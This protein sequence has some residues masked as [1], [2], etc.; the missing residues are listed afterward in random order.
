MKAS[1][2][3]CGHCGDYI[4]VGQVPHQQHTAACGKAPQLDLDAILRRNQA[5]GAYLGDWSPNLDQ[6][7]VDH[8]GEVKRLVEAARRLE[9]ANAKLAAA[10]DIA[11]ARM[12][13]AEARAQQKEP[14][15]RG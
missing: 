15:S 6:L 13:D 9:Q 11:Q 5:V 7:V 10:L 3:N 2:P 14:D 4:G 8:L 12:R 1:D